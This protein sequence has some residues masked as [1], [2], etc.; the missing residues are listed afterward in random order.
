MEKNITKKCKACE[1]NF[2]K[3]NKNKK[4]KEFH[5]PKDIPVSENMRNSINKL[6][7]IK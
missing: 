5:F 6:R 7:G 1:I 2:D 4:Q 3:L